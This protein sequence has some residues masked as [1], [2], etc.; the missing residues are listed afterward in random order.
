MSV[1]VWAWARKPD[2]TSAGGRGA[3]ASMTGKRARCDGE[4]REK[5]RGPAGEEGGAAASE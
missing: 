4:E 5:G 2:C 1:W 3:P